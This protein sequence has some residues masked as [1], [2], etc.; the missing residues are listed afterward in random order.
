MGVDY[1]L[2]LSF[3]VLLFTVIVIMLFFLMPTIAMP[4]QFVVGLYY[5]FDLLYQF[6]FILPVSLIL[7]Y[8]AS[9]LLLE[10]V[11]ISIRVLLFF[12]NLFVKTKS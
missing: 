11:I 8:F 12:V 3:G 1:V 10:S 2:R 4:G 6:N 5:F 9:S 7:F